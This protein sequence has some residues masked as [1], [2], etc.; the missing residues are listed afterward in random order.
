M[1]YFPRTTEDIG[2]AVKPKPVDQKKS[3]DFYFTNADH[4]L[5]QAGVYRAED[6]HE[7]L[8]RVLL[9]YVSFVIETAAKH[10]QWK[11]T[12]KDKCQKYEAQAVVCMEE[13]EVGTGRHRALL[14][15]VR[16]LDEK[17]RY[18]VI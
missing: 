7:E 18:F 3:L 17:Q 13:M 6:N 15:H 14:T 8:Y 2:K 16:K 9:S 4:F 11:K 10:A 5:L 1:E 12:K